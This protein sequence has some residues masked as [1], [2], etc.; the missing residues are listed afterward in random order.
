MGSS[1]F[2]K[3]LGELRKE[4]AVANSHFAAIDGCDVHWID[5]GYA[6]GLPAVLLLSAQWLGAS[7]FDAFAERLGER[8]RVVRLDLPGHGLSGAFGDE[9]YCAARYASLVRAFVEHRGLG[10]HVLVGQSHS[11]IPA[12]LLAAESTGG[13]AGLVLATSSGMPRD[14]AVPAGSPQ[15]ALHRTGSMNWYADRLRGLFKRPHS[16]TEFGAIAAAARDYGELPGREAESA[17]RLRH[18]EPDLLARTLPRVAVPALV[19]WSEASTYLPA[20]MAEAIAALLPDCRGRTVI[21]DTGH[22][23]LADAP[24]DAADLIL[25][26]LE[27][28]A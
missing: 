22:L 21:H 19:L 9:D 28:L 11:G 5:E 7:H 8:T 20:A 18:F 26:F 3:E 10:S 25:A 23:L 24:R 13:M 2:C 16:P 27:T 14:R 15:V 6:N 4:R 12:C 1:A 17:L